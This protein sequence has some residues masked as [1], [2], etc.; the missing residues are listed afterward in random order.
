MQKPLCAVGVG[1]TLKCMVCTPIAEECRLID[2]VSPY[3]FAIIVLR[4]HQRV[5]L[6][7]PLALGRRGRKAS[8]LSSVGGTMHTMTVFPITSTNKKTVFSPLIW[9]ALGS[10]LIYLSYFTDLKNAFFKELY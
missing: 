7:I 4:H 9:E 3:G 2:L 6:M 1:Q 10:K 8:V 5:N